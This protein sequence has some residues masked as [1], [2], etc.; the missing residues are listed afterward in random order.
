ME[1]GPR[2]GK[3]PRL[4]VVSYVTQRQEWLTN[5]S[6]QSLSSPLV[7][8][9]SRYLCLGLGVIVVLSSFLLA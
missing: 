7:S 1:R 5:P 9:S 3:S 4:V 2:S 6:P 8:F